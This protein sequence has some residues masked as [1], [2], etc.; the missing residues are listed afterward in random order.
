MG[1]EEEPE[2]MVF[3]NYLVKRYR[4]GTIWI[5]INEGPG[6]G[7]AMEVSEE[8]FAKWVEEFYERHF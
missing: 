4:K 5:E 3:G 2:A 8:V 1:D 6:S 7:E